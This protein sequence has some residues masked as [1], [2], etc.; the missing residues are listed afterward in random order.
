MSPAG[1]RGGR[2]TGALSRVTRGL[3]ALLLALVVGSI[4]QVLLL[5]F[6]DPPLTLTMLDRAVEATRASNRPSWPRHESLD[7]D[8]LG[9]AV[10]RAAVSSEDARFFFHSGF[11]WE[12]VCKALD[13]N[14]A[15]HRIRGGSTI[16]QQVAR[17]VFLWQERSW[18]RKGLET[19]YTVWLEL[20]LPKDRILEVYLNIAETGEMTFGMEAGA[21]RYFRK[22]ARSL[23]PDQAARLA[24]M[25]PA[26][27]S[28]SINGDTVSERAAWIQAHPAPFPDDRGFEAQRAAWA[29]RA[30]GPWDCL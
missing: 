20:L 9:E 5:R 14:E 1:G 30:L 28:W 8:E 10:A 22:P 15:G 23:S 27:R 3:G 11:D 19:W 18:L 6:V 4:S 2:R 13:N 21:L 29:E 24:S 17:N 16:T 7:R 25:L 26:P 12:G